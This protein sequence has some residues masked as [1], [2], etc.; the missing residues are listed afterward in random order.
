MELGAA[1][2][3][4]AAPAA[5]TEPLLVE[6]PGGGAVICDNEIFVKISNKKSVLVYIYMELGVILFDKICLCFSFLIFP[7]SHMIFITIKLHSDK[8]LCVLTTN[9]LSNFLADLSN[10]SAQEEISSRSRTTDYSILH[11][12]FYTYNVRDHNKI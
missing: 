3:L 5:P 11:F 10:I 2:L 7:F 9:C 12:F 6:G 4:A 8:F 1:T